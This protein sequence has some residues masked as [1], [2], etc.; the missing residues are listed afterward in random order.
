MWLFKSSKKEDYEKIL[1]D[2]EEKINKS[3]E[4]RI[5]TIANKQWAS[6]TWVIYSGVAWV[7]FSA[8]FWYFG[9]NKETPLS[10]HTFTLCTTIS[11]LGPIIVYYTNKMIMGLFNRSIRK[12]DKLI[13]ELVT[14]QKEKID[15]LKKKTEFDTTR[16]IIEKFDKQKPV[17][18]NVPATSSAQ[19]KK[20]IQNPK[21]QIGISNQNVLR[22]RN[23]NTSSINS[24]IGLGTSVINPNRPA[25]GPG[26]ES[27]ANYNPYNPTP[28]H[29]GPTGVVQISKPRND[30][31]EK[32]WLEKLVDKL[33]G[34][35]VAAN[36]RYALI[37][38]KCYS[39]NGLVLEE[40]IDT[41]QYK[42]PKC[43]FFN[44]SR[45]SLNSPAQSPNPANKHQ[46]VIREPAPTSNL[47]KQMY[48]Q[49]S[50]A[51]KGLTFGSF[52]GMDENIFESPT[53]SPRNRLQESENLLDYEQTPDYEVS[54]SE[55]SMVDNEEKDGEIIESSVNDI[56]EKADEQSEL[57]KVDESQA[58]K[59][60]ETEAQKTPEK[61]VSQNNSNLGTEN[62]TKK[63]RKGSNKKRR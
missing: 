10:S 5:S 38:R 51:Q 7:V 8:G 58:V 30:S 18:A 62:S 50:S 13:K 52:D 35:D 32:P 49:G 17:V 2:L 19:K 16:R 45:T 34:D 60:E 9:T 46:P 3:K 22:N 15:E 1:A 40:E 21:A 33:V 25:I 26:L 4:K 53:G 31:N 47:S 37:C 27:N 29:R 56:S 23:V 43:G 14:Q 39:H 6:T 12:Q 36:S 48:L 61:I 44:P 59:E 55:N 24:G 42:C 54:L 20:H 63:K 41:I 28:Q 11:I 57:E